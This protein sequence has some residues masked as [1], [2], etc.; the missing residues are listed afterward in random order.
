MDE[1]N[2]QIMLAEIR[3]AGGDKIL[4][5]LQKQLDAWLEAHPDWDK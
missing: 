1:E 3:A 4:A 5:E 2:Y